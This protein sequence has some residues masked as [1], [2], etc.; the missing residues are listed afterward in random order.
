MTKNSRL[1]NMEANS[2]DLIGQQ[3]CIFYSEKKLACWSDMMTLDSSQSFV[4]YTLVLTSRRLVGLSH[5]N[6]GRNNFSIPLYMLGP[7]NMV[8]VEDR[9]IILTVTDAV[10]T[11]KIIFKPRSDSV[12]NPCLHRACIIENARIDANTKFDLGPVFNDK[13]LV[14]G[15]VP[16]LQLAPLGAK[17]RRTAL[18]LFHETR[19][20]GR[21][22]KD[23]SRTS[24]A[25]HVNT[26]FEL[27]ET[28]NLNHLDSMIP[29]NLFPFVAGTPRRCASPFAANTC[30]ICER[31]PIQVVLGSCEH[32]ACC[33][34]CGNILTACPI[35]QRLIDE[36][37][38]ITDLLGENPVQ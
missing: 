12:F 14:D 19:G 18:E 13:Y 31:F 23:S 27:S 5:K 1:V 10:K 17:K 28:N 30:I 26:G 2:T 20:N 3:A 6:K 21:N 22:G 16:T 7:V 11:I 24:L 4:P 9:F 15:E 37:F 8:G 35:C 34:E 38:L 33:E 29:G 32:L 25:V 36:R